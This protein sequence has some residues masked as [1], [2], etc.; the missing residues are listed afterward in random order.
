[1]DLKNLSFEAAGLFIIVFSLLR[2]RDARKILKNCREAEG[3]VVG[4]ELKYGENGNGYYYPQIKFNLED[5]TSVIVK[6]H[7]GFYPAKFK[8]DD[9]V[10]I[11][12][13]ADNHENFSIKGI[14]SNL[15]LILLSV[16]VLMVGYGIYTFVK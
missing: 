9:K 3:V 14:D 1:M 2:I 4:Q 13:S 16:G 12:Y 15:D 5:G 6:Y 7:D 8:I 11:R 10:Q